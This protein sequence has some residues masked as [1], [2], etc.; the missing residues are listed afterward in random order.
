ME[1]IKQKI[2]ALQKKADGHIS[3]FHCFGQETTDALL[4]VQT[5]SNIDRLKKKLANVK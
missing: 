2:I 3:D 4:Y 5:L 1:K